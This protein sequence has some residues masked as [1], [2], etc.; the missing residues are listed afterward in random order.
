MGAQHVEGYEIGT[1]RA[2]RIGKCRCDECRAGFAAN[3]YTLTDRPASV[4][5]TLEELAPPGDWARRG[6]CR[7]A[8]IAV[9]F[10]ERG[11]DV[12]VARNICRGCPV[13]DEC[14]AYALSAPSQLQ[15]VWGGL[16]NGDRRRMR[17]GQSA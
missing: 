8:P 5:V 3:R 15:G 13:L 17:L 10:P 16:T 2:Y 4:I 9:F 1:V 6:R 7:S 12:N 14:R 11:D